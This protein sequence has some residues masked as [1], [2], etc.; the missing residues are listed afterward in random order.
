[1]TDPSPIS[2]QAPPVTRTVRICT[3]FTFDPRRR[4]DFSFA[5]LVFQDGLLVNVRA[6]PDDGTTVGPCVVGP[7]P[8]AGK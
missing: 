2:W 7:P 3:G 1:M 6:V 5:D 4:I 8:A